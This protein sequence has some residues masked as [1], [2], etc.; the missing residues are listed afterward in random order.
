[1]NRQAD[2]QTD[3][4]ADR[5]TDKQKGVGEVGD[6]LNGATASLKFVWLSGSTQIPTDAW[7][8]NNNNSDKNSRSSSCISNRRR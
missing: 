4:L 2:T 6:Q 3:G 7:S 1:M 8:N 5:E